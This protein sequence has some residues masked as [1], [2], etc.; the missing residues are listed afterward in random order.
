MF[1]WT[2]FLVGSMLATLWAG[3]FHLL[4]GRRLTDLV[5]YWFVAIVG[6]AVGQAMAD[7]LGLRWLMIGQVH[8]LEGTLACWIALFVAR[9][10]K[11]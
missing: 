3:L 11:V 8:A 4:F 5:L 10:L 1:T 2:V 6:F 9:A 7:A